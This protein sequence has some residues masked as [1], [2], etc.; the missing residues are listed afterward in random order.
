[1][2][3]N[4]LQYVENVNDLPIFAMIFFILFFIGVIIYTFRLKKSQAEY[5]RELP[6]EK[7]NEN[8]IK[9]IPGED[10]G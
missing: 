9:I 3:R 4:I 2:F 7:V 8:Y 6:F 5:Y 1:M 10:N